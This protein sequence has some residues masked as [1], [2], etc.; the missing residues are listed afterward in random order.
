MRHLALRYRPRLAPI[1]EVLEGDE[2]PESSSERAPRPSC[3]VSSLWSA[4]GRHLSPG[5]SFRLDA[6]IRGG[7]VCPGGR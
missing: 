3:L 5:G 2:R 7:R 6:R 1:T 4:A